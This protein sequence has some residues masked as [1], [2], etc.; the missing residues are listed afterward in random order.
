METLIAKVDTVGFVDAYL[1]LF[2]GGLKLTDKE[3]SIMKEFI[4]LRMQYS[5]DGAK[6][7]VPRELVFLPKNVNRIKD[8]L[9]ISKQNWGTYKDSLLIKKAIVQFGDVFDINPILIPRKEITF[10]YEVYE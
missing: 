7:D 3:F 8:K 2:N 5:K 9:A 6:G 4:L 10:K 1:K